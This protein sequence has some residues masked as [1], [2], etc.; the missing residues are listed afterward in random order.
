MLRI[1]NTSAMEIVVTKLNVNHDEESQRPNR[2]DWQK[3]KPFNQHQQ[4][5]PYEE[6]QEIDESIHEMNELQHRQHQQEQEITIEGDANIDIITIG[7]DIQQQQH[8]ETVQL[9]LRKSSE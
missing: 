4:Q 7:N 8:T 2:T 9:Q 6:I 1:Y 5:I 3:Y